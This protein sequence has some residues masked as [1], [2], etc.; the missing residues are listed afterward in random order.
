MRCPP[1]SLRRSGFTLV[2]LLVVLA[3]IALL[4]GLLLPAVQQARESARRSACKSNL[5]QIGLALHMYHNLAQ[6]FPPGWEGRDPTTFLPDIEG[7]AGWAWGAYALPYVE[8]A[9]VAEQIDF[10]ISLTD[11]IH[12]GVR[13][14]P[15]AIFLCP[16][17]GE[18]P[19]FELEA[20]DGS[21]VLARLA[22]A[23]YVGMFGTNEIEEC[24]EAPPG[25]PCLGDG[26]FFHNSRTTIGE[27]RDG[28]SQTILVGERASPPGASTWVGVWPGGEEAI[29]RVLGVA[30][31]VPNHPTG[32][33]D[34]F[35]SQ[36]PG[37]AQFLFG[38]GAVHFVADTIDEHVYRAMSTC[39][40][41]D[42][43]A[44]PDW[45]PP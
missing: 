38:D 40:A 26:A 33:F 43:V 3:I 35:G 16:S 32:H 18:V 30:D 20:E 44:A 41:G 39:A 29:V 31:H 5:R 45:T 36:H 10:S 4:V 34:D 22:R 28:A 42:F 2:E 15:Q 19:W 9:N 24:E 14:T 12:A 23:N 37:G 13:E 1:A 11:P 27:L 25:T 21:G 17:D 7:P 6:S 8:A